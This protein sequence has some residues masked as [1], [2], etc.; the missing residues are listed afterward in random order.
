MVAVAQRLDGR[1]N[2]KIG[3]AKI[4]LADAQVDDVAPLRGKLHGA[5]QNGEGVF[6]ADTVKCG[7]GLEHGSSPKQGGT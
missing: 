7:D 6:L 3:G 5:R 2:D 4:R 1:F